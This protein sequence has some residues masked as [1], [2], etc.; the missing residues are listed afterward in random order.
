M[1]A[2]GFAVG[3]FG[4]VLR[5][6]DGG[7]SWTGL[8]SGT[9]SSL[10]LVQEVD[11]NTVIVG[12]GC[13]VRESVNGGESFERLTVNESED[14]C[15]T[16][17]ASFSFLSAS[18]RFVEQADGSILATTNGGQTLQ[19][20]TPVPLERR[21]GVEDLLHLSATTGFALTGGAGGRIFRT[22]DGANSW[23]QVASSPAPLSDLTFVT[24]T[25]AFAVGADNTLLGSTDAGRQLDGARAVAAGGHAAARADAYLLQRRHYIA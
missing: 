20:K 13:T 15:P 12:G 16:K 18:T 10:S 14:D 5:S 3:E 25:T 11:P 24:P 8:A 7:S 19:P 2:R 17:V 23:T 9:K 22:T 4:T 21:H 6:D 1:G